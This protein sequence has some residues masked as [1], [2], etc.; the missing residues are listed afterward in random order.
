MIMGLKDWPCWLK[1]GIILVSINLI[2]LILDFLIFYGRGKACDVVCPF[3]AVAFFITDILYWGGNS[4][5][6]VWIFS[7]VVLFILGAII[8]WIV[9][10]VGN[11]S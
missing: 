5:T 2:M 8:G 3:S 11:R 6:A 4:G 9:G 7:S 1:G 10:K